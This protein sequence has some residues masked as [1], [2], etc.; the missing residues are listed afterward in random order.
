[1]A[2]RKSAKK[3][4]KATS[5]PAKKSVPRAG[6]KVA[7]KRS[8]AATTSSVS[9]PPKE[10]QGGRIVIKKPPAKP[11][12][13]RGA[14]RVQAEDIRDSRGL[15]IPKK[16]CEWFVKKLDAAHKVAVRVG[17]Y[18]DAPKVPHVSPEAARLLRGKAATWANLADAERDDA[19]AREQESLDLLATIVPPE[20]FKDG[21]VSLAKPQKPVAEAHRWKPDFEGEVYQAVLHYYSYLPPDHVGSITDPNGYPAKAMSPEAAQVYRDHR[22]FW[23]AKYAESKAQSKS[24]SAARKKAAEASVEKAA[25]S[26]GLSRDDLEAKLDRLA[27]LVQNG[28]LQ[29][30]ADMIAAFGDAWLYEALLAG[31]SVKPDGSLRPGKILKRFKTR[32]NLILVLAVAAM[33]EGVSLDPSLHRNAAMNIDIDCDTLEIV[34]DIGSRLPKLEPRTTGTL[35]LDDLTSLSDAAAAILAKHEGYL[36]LDGVTSLSDAAAESLSRHKDSLYLN[37]LTSLSDAAAESL[38][39]HKWYLDLDGLTSLS[40]AAAESLGKHEGDLFLSGLTSLSDAAA[41]SLSRHK[42]SLYLNGLTSLSDAAAESLAKHEEFSVSLSIQ[43]KLK[44]ARRMAQKRAT[45]KRSRLWAVAAK[46]LTPELKQIQTRLKA[47]TGDAVKMVVA[48]LESRNASEEDWSGV[49]SEQV[50]GQ[51]VRTWNEDVWKEFLKGVNSRASLLA[52]FKE[53]AIEKMDCLSKQRW[54]EFLITLSTVFPEAAAESLANHKGYL[55]L[56][57]LTS[58]SDAAAESLAKHKGHLQISADIARKI[59]VISR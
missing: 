10:W 26:A 14:K 32:A 57:G 16:V 25:T 18:Y 9:K 35:D 29:M 8:R 15:P 22:T 48:L 1:V 27:A 36:S 17:D 58:L 21:K 46:N 4:S 52:R 3:K 12:K 2:K 55:D 42:D 47:K 51:L 24:A 23:E 44:A 43:K 13:G 30:V 38:A 53:I 54:K 45:L 56:N 50:V 59:K 49:F 33:P 34:A 11:M 40:D 31:S 6:K 7:G 41:E 28:D 20:E 37:G 39:K 19:R 5:K